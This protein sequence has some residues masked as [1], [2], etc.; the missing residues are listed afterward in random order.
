MQSRVDR[1]AIWAGTILDLLLFG[2]DEDAED[3]IAVTVIELV[4]PS[5]AISPVIN[6]DNDH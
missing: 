1:L 2:A 5:L 6:R 3:A 4:L